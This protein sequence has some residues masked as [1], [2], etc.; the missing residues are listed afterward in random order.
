[1]M[2]AV[3]QTPIAPLR[4]VR[5]GDD[6]NDSLAFHRLVELAQRTERQGDRPG[7]RAL[8][9][10][11]LAR[12]PRQGSG[13]AASELLR[14]VARTHYG[15]G[16]LQLALDCAEAA[17]SLAEVNGHLGAMGHATNILA[18]I[19][20][21]QGDID[22][23]ERLYLIAR[24][25]AVRGGEPK[26][27][28]MTAQNL[29]VLGSIRGDLETALTHYATSLGAY[30]AMGMAAEVCHVLNN[31]GLVNTQ[32]ER[33]DD[34]DHAYDE[35]LRVARLLGD[36]GTQMYIEVN[37]A[38][39]SVAQNDFA[40][41]RCACDRAMQLVS[42]VTDAPAVG[43]LYKVYG[44]IDRQRGD[45]AAAERH[46]ARAHEIA[47]ARQDKVLLADTTKELAELHRQQ[48]RNRDALQCLNRAHRL[49][50]Q[51]R[52]RRDLADIDRRMGRLESDFLD[53]VRR[54]GES[55]EC[56]DDYTQGHCERVA[57]IACALAMR[58]GMDEQSLFWFRIGA[59]LHDVG[60][61]VIPP[62]V[63][64]KRSPLSAAEWEL[65][66]SHPTAGVEM[67]ADVE[68][69]WDVSPIVQGHHERWD[70]QG[71]PH[72]LAGEAIPRVARMVSI[73]DVYDALTSERSYKKGMSPAA[74]MEVMRA[75]V[76]R[77]FDPAL[78][79]LFEQ[80]AV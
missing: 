3:H 74:A 72:G 6:G 39:W 41:A 15:D 19:R 23:A 62:A 69:P 22:E 31:V 55:I 47:T 64:N 33:W 54:W 8:Y 40:S 76:G 26:L 11:A 10:K 17:L 79:A 43:E 66:R 14:W 73:A 59:L 37:R 67:L 36:H 60:K 70:G 5:G 28:A 75:D 57:D 12:L 68:F 78:F 27:A 2:R 45:H 71:Y 48:G 9:E 46:L 34:A 58:D 4:L 52:A 29:G 1:M 38:E 42:L 63:L 30:R 18:G 53:V 77:Q 80:V 7:A 20:W 35:A 61:L 56:N 49:Y 50:T 21:R 65:M 51:L 32:F 25:H 24:Q 16:E 13:V 44:V